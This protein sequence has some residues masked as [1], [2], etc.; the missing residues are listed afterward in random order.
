[1]ST[2]LPEGS[3]KPSELNTLAGKG[4]SESAVPPITPETTSPTT[5]PRRRAP[6]QAPTQASQAEEKNITDSKIVN[7]QAQASL[8]DLAS[9]PDASLELF[10]ALVKESDFD[11]NAKDSI[12]A[13]LLHYAAG[14]GN[15]KVVK[16]L[17]KNGADFNIQTDSGATPLDWAK[18]G[19]HKTVVSTI[20]AANNKNRI[21]LYKAASTGDLETVKELVID[22]NINPKFVD[23]K[24]GST[25]LHAAAKN[26]HHEIV[27]WLMKNG[28]NP[29]SQNKDGATPL[30]LAVMNGHEAVVSTILT[31]KKMDD[32]GKLSFSAKT[33]LKDNQEKLPVDYIHGKEHAKQMVNHFKNRIGHEER[34]QQRLEKEARRQQSQQSTTSEEASQVNQSKES[35]SSPQQHNNDA[36]LLSSVSNIESNL[37]QEQQDAIKSLVEDAYADYQ[38]KHSDAPPAGFVGEFWKVKSQ[39]LSTFNDM[40]KDE[41]LTREEKQKL[42]DEFTD[43]TGQYLSEYVN[44]P[45]FLNRVTNGIAS[46]FLGEDQE[47]LAQAKQQINTMKNV[48]FNTDPVVLP[49]TAMF[50]TSET[51]LTTD[52]KI[53]IENIVKETCNDDTIA[54]LALFHPKMESSPAMLKMIQPI[55]K[56]QIDSLMKK[57][58]EQ[59]PAEALNAHREDITRYAARCICEN[60]LHG[61]LPEE[62]KGE[63]KQIIEGKIQELAANKEQ[64]VGE[65]QAVIKDPKKLNEKGKTIQQ[66]KAPKQNAA[67]AAAPSQPPRRDHPPKTQTFFG[68]MADGIYHTL[69]GNHESNT[70]QQK[71]AKPQQEFI[72]LVAKFQGDKHTGLRNM[73]NYVIKQGQDPAKIDFAH[74]KELAQERNSVTHS[75][76]QSVRSTLG[77]FGYAGSDNIRIDNSSGKAEEKHYRTKAGRHYDIK[78][79]YNAVGNIWNDEP[80]NEQLEIA[81]AHLE[82]YN[83]VA[84]AEK[85]VLDDITNLLP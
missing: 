30:H 19:E 78:C 12:G 44:Q 83:E 2:K 8:Y 80:T 63:E 35:S 9:R 6:A 49:A 62:L 1:M 37:T 40:I 79:F 36:S 34:D 15:N 42:W 66:A 65:V 77:K 25:P 4:T 13:T 51:R 48:F 38:N 45:A 50:N 75:F 72:D 28:S 60:N 26:G 58:S 64:V 41:R 59:F 61:Q 68:R 74:L 5:P 70:P 20:S 53:K 10:T 69:F 32:S 17:I 46:V 16:W 57:L 27:K 52:V 55:W 84:Y 85:S 3:K 81:L 29:N 7:A 73:A 14:N 71:H 56:S 43:Y 31:D 54:F 47:A 24:T 23:K 76:G 33:N 82:H 21:L 11:I 67:P 22:K 39:L 18:E